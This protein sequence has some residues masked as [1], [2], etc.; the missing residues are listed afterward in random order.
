MN[1]KTRSNLA[2]WLQFPRRVILWLAAFALASA[3][4]LSL[5]ETLL[6]AA[7][8]GMAE[9]DWAVSTMTQRPVDEMIG[10]RLPNSLLLLGAGLAL[11]LIL[12]EDRNG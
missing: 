11:A 6:G 10:E 2:T 12:A 3:F 7:G 8:A 9:L 1:A 5:R 4:I